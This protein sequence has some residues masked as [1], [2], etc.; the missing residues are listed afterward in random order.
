MY[1][2]SGEIPAGVYRFLPMDRVVFGPG[3]VRR[4]PQELDRLRCHHALVITGGSISSRTDL[5]WY[6]EQLLGPRHAATYTGARQHVPAAT[7]AEAAELARLAGADCLVS[8]GGGSPIDTAKAVGHR[9]AFGDSPAAPD[10][11]PAAHMDEPVPLPHFA[12]P[13][14]LSAGEF[15]HLAG[16]TDEGTRFKSGVADPRLVPRAV[17]LDPEMTVPTPPMLW[18][19][20]GI[21]A[22]DHAV[23]SFCSPDHQPITDALA[24]EAVRLLFTYLPRTR[25]EPHDLAPRM[26]CQIG[27]WMSLF[28]AASVRGG[29]SHALGH[30]I[31]A[32]C[33]IPHGVT[34]CITLPHVMRFLAPAA[35]ARQ[36][37]LAH[38]I[39][40]RPGD[41]DPAD[42]AAAA[43]DAVADLV[44]RLGLPARL[45]DAGVPAAEIMP[46]AAAAFDEAAARPSPR[47]RNGV[48]ELA[49]L[50]RSMW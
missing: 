32:R 36:A 29:L 7:V 12:V 15:T 6:V 30:Q 25:E 17:F 8:L 19:A 37:L 43:A 20:T 3:V 50:L 21:K 22:L 24:L 9:L 35:A 16:V 18:L 40:V 39:G 2:M 47:P 44:R 1:D 33:D 4:L 41:G 28:N 26:Q 42:L 49:A 27:A 14:T 38:A 10:G 45:R 34:S 48:D 11:T 5:L 31:G 46:I 13:T 23:E